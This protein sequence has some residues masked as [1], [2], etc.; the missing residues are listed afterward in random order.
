MDDISITLSSDE[1]TT[2]R[3]AVLFHSIDGGNKGADSEGWLS[4]VRAAYRDLYAATME[5]A[6]GPSVG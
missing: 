4:M 1:W 3:L 6:N 2:I 5:P